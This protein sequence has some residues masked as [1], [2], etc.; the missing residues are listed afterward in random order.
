MLLQVNFFNPKLAAHYE[1]KFQM[2]IQLLHR[3][4]MLATSARTYQNQPQ[5]LR[6]VR[7]MRPRLPAEYPRIR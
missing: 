7:P 4:S 6:S 2:G 5:E 1:Q 3:I